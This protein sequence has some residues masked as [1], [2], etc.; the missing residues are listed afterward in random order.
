MFTSD[1]GFDEKPDGEVSVVF[2]C[3]LGLRCRQRQRRPEARLRVFPKGFG[4]FEY[5]KFCT[6]RVREHAGLG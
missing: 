5:T 1:D 3:Q 6:S 2:E 4:R